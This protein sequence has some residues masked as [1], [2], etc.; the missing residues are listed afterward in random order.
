[1]NCKEIGEYLIDAA[2]GVA[3][4][5]SVEAH[6]RGCPACSQRLEEMRRTMAL[7]DEWKA[8]E[9]SP[10][11]ETRL[12][13]RLRDEKA[14]PQGWMEWFRRPVLATAMAALLIAGGTLFTTGRYT[15][16]PQTPSAAVQDLQDLDKNRD[17]FANFD[18]LD[19]VAA[20]RTSQSA[21]P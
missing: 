12:Q 13:A 21:N 2:V 4:E 20:D 19:D 7:L 16:A 3:P 1:M 17:L 14:R 5:V 8:P 9:P 15:P 11:F 10:Y 6:L 18:L